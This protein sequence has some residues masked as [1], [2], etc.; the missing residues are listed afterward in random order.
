MSGMAT[1]HSANF[2]TRHVCPACGRKGLAQ[3]F[4]VVAGEAVS[5]WS[6][7]YCRQV[8]ETDPRTQQGA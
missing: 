1:D 7:R 2:P 8:W 6:C 4:G 3:H 5:N